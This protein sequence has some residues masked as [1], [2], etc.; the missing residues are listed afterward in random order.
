[1]QRKFPNFFVIGAAKSGTSSLHKYLA[2]HPDIYMSPAKEPNYFSFLGESPNFSGPLVKTDNL[3]F[4]DRLKRAKYEFSVTSLREYEQL[5]SGVRGESAI[6]ESSVSYL[7][8]PA[9][10]SR[11]RERVPDAKLIAILRNPVTRAYSKYQQFR[12][13]VSE[14]LFDFAEALAAEPDR[15]R[16][17]W[18]PTWFY[19]DRGFYHRQLR[20][21]YELFD[22]NQIYICL[23]EDFCS[24]PRRQLA[25]IFRFL[26]V[27][28]DFQVDLAKKHNVS[29]SLRVP[30][31]MLLY[32]FFMNP[33]G[34]SSAVRRLLPNRII[35]WSRPLIR[36][37]I[38][39]ESSEADFAPLSVEIA[40]KLRKV[41][42]ND[43]ENLEKLI[44]RDLS[45]WL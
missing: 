39:R 33:S 25:T 13:V 28:D 12:R 22:R 3:F 1:M 15:I 34:F 36:K 4:R 10:A 42:R 16:N 11:I 14:P 44:Q 40:T 29:E 17:N 19:V 27:S 20:T 43:I 9:V 35:K 8:F 2:Q 26:E 23:Y 32:D 38:T 21:Y 37:V 41:F 45:S 31:H 6:G 30:R 5:F 24:N 18:S 7:Y